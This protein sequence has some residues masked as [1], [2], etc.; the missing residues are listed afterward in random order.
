[1][2]KFV[3][4]NSSCPN[5][6]VEYNLNGFDETAECGGCAATLAGQVSNIPEPIIETIE[7]V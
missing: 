1:M 3:C 2:K 7:S 6:E 5:F 4:D